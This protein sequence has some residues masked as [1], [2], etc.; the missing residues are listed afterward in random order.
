M[1]VMLLGG[2]RRQTTDRV[3]HSVGLAMISGIGEA[4]GP[5]Q[6]LAVIH[7]ANDSDWQSACEMVSAAYVIGEEPADSVAPVILG[8]YAERPEPEEDQGNE[9]EDG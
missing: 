2:G 7:A 8:H 5:D 9:R 4:V 1:A 3:D 6:P